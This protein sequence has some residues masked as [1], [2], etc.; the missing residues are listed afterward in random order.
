[1]DLSHDLRVA[2]V[3]AGPA[4]CFVALALNKLG[5]RVEMYERDSTGCLAT[6]PGRGAG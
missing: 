5:L 2:V 6:E 3:G 4:G 1:M